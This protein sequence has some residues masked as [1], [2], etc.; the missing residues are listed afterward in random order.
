L[1]RAGVAGGG[2]TAGGATWCYFYLDAEEG[3]NK[4]KARI[5]WLQFFGP[6]TNQTD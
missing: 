2:D 1:G 5:P 3:K 4:K 6:M